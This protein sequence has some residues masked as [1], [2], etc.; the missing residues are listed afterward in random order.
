MRSRQRKPGIA[1]FVN[2]PIGAVQGDGCKETARR[3]AARKAETMELGVR[4]RASWRWSGQ[5]VIRPVRDRTYLGS[6]RH[7]LNESV[8]Q[9]SNNERHREKVYSVWSHWEEEQGS[10]DCLSCLPPQSIFR[11]LT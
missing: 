3:P 1:P 9:K 5:G 2:A 11:V 6:V 10:C 4:V 7:L 8:I